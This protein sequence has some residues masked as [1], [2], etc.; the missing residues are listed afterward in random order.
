LGES[1]ST[2]QLSKILKRSRNTIQASLGADF[3][4]PDIK[5]AEGPHQKSLWSRE[6]VYRV[7]LYYE[8]VTSGWSRRNAKEDSNIGSWKDV[9]GKYR[10]L[11][12]RS[13][14]LAHPNLIDLVRWEHLGDLRE[15]IKD[16]DENHDVSKY[17]INLEMIKN[18]V[19][20]G[21]ENLKKRQ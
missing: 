15:L 10:Y 13:K 20:T 8:M 4:I 3:I 2:F 11:I 19:D 9:P 14:K 7:A 16:E 6:G 12:R 5:R 21:I 18:F 1:L 17:I